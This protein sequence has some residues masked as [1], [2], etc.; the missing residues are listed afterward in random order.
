MEWC[1]EKIE[2]RSIKMNWTKCAPR[3]S[4]Q[5]DTFWMRRSWKAV[6]IVRGCAQ[7]TRWS[8]KWSLHPP[9]KNCKEI[10]TF[11][12][13]IIIHLVIKV[14]HSFFSIITNCNVQCSHTLWPVSA[15]CREAF[16]GK[17]TMKELLRL[18]FFLLT[19]KVNKMERKSRL[20]TTR[21]HYRIQCKLHTW[22]DV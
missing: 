5:W 15:L 22:N 3:G 11:F 19:A 14:S 6:Y 16:A 8:A 17:I 9:E 7:C 18:I 1:R 2:M 12:G 21:H 20:N 13:R 4:F 10:R